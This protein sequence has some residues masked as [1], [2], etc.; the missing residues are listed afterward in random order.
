MCH[1]IGDGD[2][3]VTKKLN[4]LSPYG[5]TFQIK[6]IECVNHLLR[7]YSSKLT[8]LARNTKFPIRIRKHILANILRFRGDVIKAVKHWKNTD[9]L[10]KLEKIKGLVLNCILTEE[11][12]FIFKNECFDL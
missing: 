1:F 7:N 12:N 3:S 4:E 9:G 6:K 8:A 11:I 5:P 10:S 2:S